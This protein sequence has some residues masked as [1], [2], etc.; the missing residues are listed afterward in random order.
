[1]FGTGFLVLTT[2]MT[3]NPPLQ[4][5]WLVLVVVLFKAP[6]IAFAWWL[7]AR[8]KEVPG[9]PVVWSETETHE[10]LRYLTTQA[11]ESLDQHDAEVR[12]KY[13]SREAWHVA[14]RAD[15]TLKAD[16]VGV[17]LEI[18]R[19]AARLGGRRSA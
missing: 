17:A 9:V 8:N 12:L 16:A 14:D 2:L 4:I 1:M 3:H 11:R 13:L 15:G 19:L 5:V 18:D 6:L 10:I 7:I